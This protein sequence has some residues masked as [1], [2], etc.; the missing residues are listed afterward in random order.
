MTGYQMARF[1]T[2]VRITDGLSAEE[3]KL[4]AR[5]QVKALYE[6]L[7]DRGIRYVDQSTQFPSASLQRVLLPDEVLR[8]KSANCIDGA[9]LFSSLMLRAGL[10]PIIIIVPG[11]SFVGWEAWE[12]TREYEV[13]ETTKL[14]YG[15]FE[16]AMEEG[17]KRAR[18]SEI[19]KDLAELRFRRGIFRKGRCTILDVRTLKETMTDI[20][21]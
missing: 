14:S 6:V 11:H 18:E 12:G 5:E 3:R 17:L 19:D 10:H 4:W 8:H 15:D 21:V 2:G 16:T 13:L 20:P 9:V 7:K 1:L